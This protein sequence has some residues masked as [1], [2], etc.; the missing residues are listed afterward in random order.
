MN[1]TF[2]MLLASWGILG[3][4][5]LSL[6]AYRSQLGR[7]EDDRIHFTDREAALVNQ[8][9][10]FAHRI[11]IIEKWGKTL[12]VLLVLYGIALGGYYVYTL[13]QLQATRT[14]VD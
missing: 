7:R 6:A 14:I 13:F 2:L 10:Q 12:T 5:V 11:D 1:S 4:T 9:N 8:Q 3:V